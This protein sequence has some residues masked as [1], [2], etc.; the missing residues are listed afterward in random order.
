MA[1]LLSA[2]VYMCVLNFAYLGLCNMES[3]VTGFLYRFTHVVACISIL[4]YCKWC[5]CRY[6]TLS[7][8][9]KWWMVGLFRFWLFWIM[10]LW[11]YILKYFCGLIF[12]FLIIIST[13]PELMGHMITVLH[14]WGTVKA[15]KKYYTISQSSQQCMSVLISAH[16]SSNCF[17]LSFYFSH[18]LGV[19]WY[20]I[21][22]W[23]EFP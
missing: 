1:H 5:Y 14:I 17:C 6:I 20:F 16:L 10:F 9:I 2:C 18:P 22:F 12:P 4:F 3:F 13:G 7:L 23:F 21:W 8:P 15:F 11:K 19:K